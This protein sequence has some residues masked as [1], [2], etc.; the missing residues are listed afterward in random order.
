MASIVSLI[1]GVESVA[2]S[3]MV[4]TSAEKAMTRT[5]TTEKK[6][7]VKEENS[8]KINFALIIQ[9]FVNLGLLQQKFLS[10]WHT[11]RFK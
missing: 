5:R 4:L 6:T 3:V 1:I 7:G 8:R 9:F 10:N 11:N 2:N